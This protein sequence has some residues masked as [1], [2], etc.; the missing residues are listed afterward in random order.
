MIP[1]PTFFPLFHHV[2]MR[3]V[4]KC[5]P[6]MIALHLCHSPGLLILWQHTSK[7]KETHLCT[8]TRGRRPTVVCWS[9]CLWWLFHNVYTHQNIKFCTFN[10]HNF[11]LLIV[12]QQGW[13][14][15]IFFAYESRMSCKNNLKKKMCV[16]WFLLIFPRSS[17]RHKDDGSAS[18]PTLWV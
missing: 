12:P 9:A 16:F 3:G 18:C 5:L 17:N 10:W 14:K 1:Q 11:Y 15:I 8:R 4:F 13:E 7:K 2:V 6:E